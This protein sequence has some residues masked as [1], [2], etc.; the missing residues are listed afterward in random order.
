MNLLE[1]LRLP[2]NAIRL[3]H[4][5]VTGSMLDRNLDLGPIILYQPRP[6]PCGYDLKAAHLQLEAVQKLIAN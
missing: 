6:G 1:G 4:I 3:N 2:I 5:Q